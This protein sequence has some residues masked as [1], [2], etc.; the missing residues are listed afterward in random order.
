MP[1]STLRLPFPFLASLCVLALVGCG[2]DDPSSPGV[3]LV[4]PEPLA[5]SGGLRDFFGSIES[6]TPTRL[7]VDGRTFV[8]DDQTHVFRQGAEVGYGAL[9]VGDLVVVKARLNVRAQLVARE[10]KLRVDDPPDIKVSGHVE[11][12]DPPDLVVAGRVV[13]TNSGTIV[14][15]VG[16]PRSVADLRVGSQVT[17]TGHEGDDRSILATR[18]R[19]EARR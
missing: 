3:S 19:V 11:R 7:V 10:I 9:A 8:V 18:I 5:E 1:R 16:D 6:L 2:G 14:L 17:V 12:L 4:V 13:H 15:G